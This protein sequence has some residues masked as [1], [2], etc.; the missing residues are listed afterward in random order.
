MYRIGSE[1]CCGE[2]KEF[3]RLIR[4]ITV[5]ELFK[6]KIPQECDI[7]TGPRRYLDKL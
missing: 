3:R 7:I 4:L 2:I 5:S 1:R 6:Y